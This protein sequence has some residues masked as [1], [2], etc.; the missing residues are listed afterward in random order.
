MR[1]PLHYSFDPGAVDD[2]VTLDVPLHLLNALD[3]VRLSWLV[4]GFVADKAAALIRSLPKALRR[5]YV[6][7]P[8]FAHAFAQAFQ[9][10]SADE[11][12]GELARFL[13][14]I[15]GVRVAAIDF[16][17]QTLE[18]YLHLRV[19]LHDESGQVLAESRDFDALRARFGSHWAR[20]S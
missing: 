17:E 8:D 2:G 6:P 4:P 14:R 16:D 11:M 20:R 13:S 18:P 12:R 7:T 15:T 1:L 19:R 3:P 9:Q 10:P 5:S